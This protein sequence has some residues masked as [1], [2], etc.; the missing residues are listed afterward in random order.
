MPLR[1]S[2]PFVTALLILASC[3]S[4]S[5]VQAVPAT[6]A[7]A[8][9]PVGVATT[10]HWPTGVIEPSEPPPS[11]DEPAG[12]DAETKEPTNLDERPTGTPGSSASSKAVP[13]DKQR[14]PSGTKAKDRI[15]HSDDSEELSAI[16]SVPGDAPDTPDAESIRF[17][18]GLFPPTITTLLCHCKG[19]QPPA[20]EWRNLGRFHAITVLTLIC[21]VS[22]SKL[23][24]LKSLKSLTRLSLDLGYSTDIGNEVLNIVGEIQSLENLSLNLRG[25]PEQVLT[26][27][28]KLPNLSVLTLSP[29]RYSR[30][31]PPSATVIEA[32]G[33]LHRL[34]RLGLFY[35]DL[36]G[37]GLTPLATSNIEALHLM[38]CAL[39]DDLHTL[40]TIE[41]LKWLNIGSTNA[42]DKAIEHIAATNP[43]LTTLFLSNTKVTN[44][45]MQALTALKGLKLLTLRGTAVD[46]LGR[47]TLQPLVSTGLKLH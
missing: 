40:P 15:I 24:G 34:Q 44:A 46:E 25:L 38:N 4:P 1:L 6:V 42:S 16:A 32:L 10:T 12:S 33:K 21:D 41:T 27:L 47:Q 31:A 45:G 29:N 37:V 39:D 35:W 8:E 3:K 19:G 26:P 14:Q 18:G 23:A 22:A 5:P 20:T 36:K 17:C 13:S 2:R 7:E 28:A 9:Q 43:G 30:K 11:E